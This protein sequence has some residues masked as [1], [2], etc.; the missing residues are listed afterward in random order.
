MEDTPVAELGQL[1]GI[2]IKDTVQRGKAIDVLAHVDIEN[3]VPNSKR[4]QNMGQSEKE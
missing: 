4:E 2:P 3:A 1:L